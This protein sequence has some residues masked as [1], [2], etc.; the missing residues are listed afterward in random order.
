MSTGILEHINLTVSDPD[1]T[2]ARLCALFGWKVRWSGQA[3]S[4]GYTVH[5]GSDQCYLAVY[6][7]GDPAKSNDSSYDRVCG[8]NHVGVLVD[9][10]QSVHKKV[11]D[12]GFETYNFGDYE[13]GQ[14]FYFRDP[15]GIEFEVISYQDTSKALKKSLTS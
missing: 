13:P 15:D 11:T 1:A 5:V 12:A 10:L 8:L 6:S 2:A 14:R 7:K 9:D 3:I 4:N